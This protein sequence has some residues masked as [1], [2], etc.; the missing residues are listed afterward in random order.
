LG[1]TLLVRSWHKYFIVAYLSLFIFSALANSFSGYATLTFIAISRLLKILFP[2]A[3]L[4]ALIYLE[5]TFWNWFD[6]RY[7]GWLA[8]FTVCC[9]L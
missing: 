5:K 2:F 7:I 6:E 1:L 3:G 4:G 9:P 8:V